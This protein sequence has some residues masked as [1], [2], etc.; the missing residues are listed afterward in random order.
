VAATV[1]GLIDRQLRG[2]L[3]N[4][5]GMTAEQWV[6]IFR[7]ALR[8]RGSELLRACDDAAYTMA[9][10]WHREFAGGSK[11]W[12]AG[13]S[14][15]WACRIARELVDRLRRHIDDV[16]APGVA[17]L[18]TM[19]PPDIVAVPPQVDAAL[20]S[21]RGVMTNADQVLATALD[22]FR[23]GVRRQLFADAA[24]RIADVMRVVG[25]EMLRP[26]REALGE[27]MVLLE[28]ARAEAPTDVG[29]AR[30][31]TDQYAAWPADADELVPRGSP[32]P[33]TK[34]C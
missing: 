25:A 22:G 24:A 20:R 19:G 34:C 5:E 4:P 16:L 23:A 18:G 2:Y 3:P 9:F 6:P 17:Q 26:L 33:T 14:R 7:Q 12:W 10:N 13:R 29:L 32:R 15:R 21:M 27:A 11:R 1:N 28:Q 8:N 31:T 30:L